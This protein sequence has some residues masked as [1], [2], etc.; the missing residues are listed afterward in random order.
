M[1]MYQSYLSNRTPQEEDFVEL[2]RKNAQ[3]K[4]QKIIENWP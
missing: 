3:I 4:Q 2:M 1:K